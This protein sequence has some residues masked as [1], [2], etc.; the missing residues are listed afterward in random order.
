[1]SRLEKNMNGNSECC[2]LLST[3]QRLLGGFPKF[4]ELKGF[5]FEDLSGS[6]LWI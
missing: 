2:I 1:M 4:S 6:V 3:D 5:L